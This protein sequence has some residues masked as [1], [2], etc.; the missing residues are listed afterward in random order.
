MENGK[1]KLLVVLAAIL[2]LAALVGGCHP[3]LEAGVDAEPQAESQANEREMVCEEINPYSCVSVEEGFEVTFYSRTNKKFFSEC[4]PQEPV[5]SQVADHIFEVSIS[6]GSPAAYIFYVDIENG[7][8]SETFFNPLFFGKCCVAYMEDGQLVLRDIFNKD[9]LYM[10][11]S[12]DFT[13]TAN[14]MSAIISIEIQD[15]GDVVLS[16]YKGENFEET[17]EVIT[18]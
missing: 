16:Y 18:I 9:L 12:R 11:I 7:E 3:H 10:T 14:P 6:V 4:Y 15:G 1:K 2:A 13:R 5:I 17:S 8:L